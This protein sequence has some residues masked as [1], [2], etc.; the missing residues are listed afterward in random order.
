MYYKEV[1]QEERRPPGRGRGALW[2]RNIYSRDFLARVV[3]CIVIN[4][5]RGCF[6]NRD[7]N[8]ECTYCKST[9]ANVS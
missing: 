5:P 7:V 1:I 6:H 3:V 2:N 8:L 4:N 9:A